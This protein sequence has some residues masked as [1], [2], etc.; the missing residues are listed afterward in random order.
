MDLVSLTIGLPFAPLRSLLA[1]ARTLQS[2][3]EQEL[4][5]T[6]QVRRQLEEIAAARDEG[7]ISEEEAE[8]LEEQV[9]R[10][11]VPG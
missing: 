2:E 7:Q 1:L 10:R 11:L 8:Q 6:A 9:L 4:Y 5:G 3:A